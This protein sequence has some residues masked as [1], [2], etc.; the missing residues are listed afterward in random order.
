MITRGTH[1]EFD[2][3]FYL[4]VESL[5]LYEHMCFR[6]KKKLQ[7]CVPSKEDHLL[8]ETYAKVKIQVNLVFGKSIF[9]LFFIY[10]V[11]YEGTTFPTPLFPMLFL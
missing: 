11:F 10:F 7:F 5:V 8:I 3:F 4:L 6:S 1:S 9:L 2:V